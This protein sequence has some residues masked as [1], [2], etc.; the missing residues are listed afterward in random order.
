MSNGQIP[1]PWMRGALP[2]VN[3][4]VAPLLYSFQMAREDLEAF[5][6]GL[7]T[8]QIW[9]RPFGFNAVGREIRHI[10]GSVDRLTTYLEGEQL[11]EQQMEELKSEAES[12]TSR[13]DLLRQLEQRLARSESV[14]RALDPATF[15]DARAIGRKRLPTTVI[16]LIVHMAEHTQRHVGQ[17]IRA[18]Q[19]AREVSGRGISA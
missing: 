14:M 9:A 6:E 4:F 18:A 7:T 11:S 19:L 8:E 17:A 13:E 1:E 15:T 16:G 2:G 12:G 10:G 5:T 3:P